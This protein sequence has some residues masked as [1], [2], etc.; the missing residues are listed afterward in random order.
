MIDTSCTGLMTI[1]SPSLSQGKA[2][3]EQYFWRL[4]AKCTQVS[5]KTCCKAV[6]DYFEKALDRLVSHITTSA[7]SG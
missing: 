5:K 2:V 3:L 4:L 7:E 6:G 1:D